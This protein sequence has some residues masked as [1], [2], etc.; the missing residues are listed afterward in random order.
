MTATESAMIV[1]IHKFRDKLKAGQLCLGPG[2]SLTDPAVTEALCDSADFIWLDLEH[3]PISLES[4]QAHLIASRAGGTPILVRVP[5]SEVAWVKRVL[6][7]GA[8]GV[9]L[10]Q[11]GSVAEVEQFVAAC[12]YPPQGRRGFGP[13]R[14]TNYGR[15]NLATYLAAANREVFVAIQI[16][17][18]AALEAVDA[19]VQV[20]GIDSLVIG[21]ADLAGALVGAPGQVEH[22][23]VMEAIATICARARAAGLFVGIGMGADIE[24]A[25]RVARL[26]VQWIQCGGDCSFMIRAADAT[27]Q[28]IRSRLKESSPA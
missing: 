2:V 1:N 24:Y 14:A 13:R 27:Y 3:S 20:P 16:E 28:G 6:D 8:E 21:P 15:Q 10:P 4:L 19:L 26:G 9:I 23:R 25:T 12:R 22:P 5:S 18:A 11:A 7:I 17:T